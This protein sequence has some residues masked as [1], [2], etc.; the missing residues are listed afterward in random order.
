MPANAILEPSC[1][2]AGAG[3]RERA[4]STRE[5]GAESMSTTYAPNEE[6]SAELAERALDSN[7]TLRPSPLMEGLRLT[8]PGGVSVTRR[9]VPFSVCAML[10][11]RHTAAAAT[12][13]RTTANRPA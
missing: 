1:E 6:A 12:M 11:T 13:V 3:A 8:R 7:A 10:E 5:A 2:T 4:T 9:N